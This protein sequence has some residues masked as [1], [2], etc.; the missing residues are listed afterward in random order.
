MTDQQK[1]ELRHALLTRYIAA[2]IQE[3][4]ARGLKPAD[5]DHELISEAIASFEGGA[6]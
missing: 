6:R 5:I 1:K 4:L 3:E 2:Y